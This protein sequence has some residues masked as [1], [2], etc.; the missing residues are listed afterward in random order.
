MARLSTNLRAQSLLPALL[1]ATL[2]VTFSLLGPAYV[3][4]SEGIA[5]ALGVTLALLVGIAKTSSA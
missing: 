5:I 4:L 2:G 3:G 1:G